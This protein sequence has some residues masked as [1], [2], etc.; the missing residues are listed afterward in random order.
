MTVPTDRTPRAFDHIETWVFDLDNTLYPH[1]VNLWQQVDERIR[2]YIARLSQGLRRRGLPPAEGLLQALRHLDARPDDRARHGA[3]R[4]PR[5]RAPD[6]PLADRAEP[7]AG[8]GHRDAS[9]PQA[10][11]DQR[12]A[13]ACRRGAGTARPARSLR[14]RVRHHRRRARAQA[15]AR[16]PTSASSRRMRS[17][18]TRRRCSKTSRAT[19]PF[20]T[21]SA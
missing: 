19:W 6:R 3:R 18:P 10:D 13:A 21:R 1:H 9:R 4:L 5:L 7:G 12:H 2:D 15:L 17:T 11:P 16:R 20:R 8:R 14:A